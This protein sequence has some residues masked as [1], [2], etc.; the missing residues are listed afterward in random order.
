MDTMKNNQKKSNKVHGLF[1]F[2]F[3]DDLSY[4]ERSDD[5]SRNKSDEPFVICAPK[6]G[7][8]G[9]DMGCILATH[10]IMNRQ[11]GQ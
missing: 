5:D 8:N 6:P 7:M 11:I 9:V 4:R 10:S 1:S 3:R 2:L